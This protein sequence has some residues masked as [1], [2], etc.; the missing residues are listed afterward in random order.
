[1]WTIWNEINDLF[2]NNN[3]WHEAKLRKVM[4]EGLIDYE[5][6]ERQHV[7]QQIQ[8]NPDNDNTILKAIDTNP[9]TMMW[10]LV[11]TSQIL[12][13][14]FLKY[15]KLAELAMVHIIGSVENERCLSTL[16][17]MKSKFH[18]KLTIH[19]PIVVCMFALQFYI[20]ENFPYAECIE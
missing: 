7:L 20:L 4:W 12:V 2:F 13:S 15:M 6:F 1:M 3:K 9:L 5:T 10:H 11:I 16:A 14:N 18:N 19:F 8:K 17:F